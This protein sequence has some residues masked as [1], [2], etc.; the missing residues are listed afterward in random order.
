MNKIRYIITTLVFCIIVG[1]FSA[2]LLIKNPDEVSEWERRK[3]AQFPEVSFSNLM[4]GKF[5][6]DFE[7]YA[8]DQFPLRN[9]F[10][11]IK[12]KVLFDLY[13]Q[14]DNNGIYVVDGHASNMTA[15]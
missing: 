7:T 14:K 8:N 1:G 2:W 10:R 5:M 11:R 13:R 9:T 6:R 15:R 4:E 3:L 12:A